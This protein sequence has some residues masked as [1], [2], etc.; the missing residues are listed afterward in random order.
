M[1]RVFAVG[2][3]FGEFDVAFELGVADDELSREVGGNRLDHEIRDS[4]EI[5]PVC[6]R[7]VFP[8]GLVWEVPAFVEGEGGGDGAIDADSDFVGLVFWVRVF[9]CVGLVETVVAVDSCSW[10][11]GHCPGGATRGAVAAVAPGEGID[12]T[13]CRGETGSYAYGVRF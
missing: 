10:G 2:A 5:V 7:R 12:S 4:L 8:R 6:V 3:C 1:P 13:A 9:M 11:A